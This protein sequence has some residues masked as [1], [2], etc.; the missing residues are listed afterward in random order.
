ML[1]FLY[2]DAGSR[3]CDQQSRRTWLQIGT[4]SVLGS[5]AA[6]STLSYRPRVAAANDTP[7]TGASPISD[8]TPGTKPR[9][10]ACIQIFLWGGPGAQ[11]TW[12]LK[13]AAPAENRGDFRPISTVVPGTQICEHLPRLAQRADQYTVVRSLTHE[14][15]NHG[16]SAYHMLTGHLHWSPGTLRHPTRN[17][18]PNIG[19]NAARHLSHPLHLPAHVHLP[20]IVNDGDGLP[21]PGQ[22]PGILGEAHQPFEVL[23]DLTA[24]DFKVSTLMRADGVSG[25]RLQKRSQL[26]HSLASQ[27]DYLAE[28]REGK[29]LSSYYERALA[30]L[31]SAQ[32]EAAF[33]LTQ[34]LETLRNAYGW[35]HFA[36]SLLLARRLVEA[37][38][39]FVTVYWNS[40]RN[41]DN[42]SWDTHNNQHVRMKDHLLPHFDQAMSAFLDDL[43]NRGLM[44]DVLVTWYGEF[45]RT[46]VINRAGG[47]DHWGFC[48]SIGLTGAGI[49]RGMVYGT[50]TRDGGYADQNP[51]RPDDLSATIFHLLG[52]DHTQHMYD[53]QNRPAPLSYGQVVT[54]LL[55]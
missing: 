14:G 51:V 20:S 34:E 9:A 10:K 49:R 5:A 33:D 44:D 41:T 26:V 47:R 40:P 22:G 17:D 19:V 53:L 28:L 8:S 32:T 46:P 2:P 39:P 21:V 25:E 38:V 1:N 6:G 54:D 23:G 4:A 13:P 24:R 48:Q 31:G 12:D 18:M 36:Q 7:G 16:T 11:E 45:G 3:L 42:Q 52:I 35:H 29:A 27:A 15:V 30:L 43:Q 50:S 55:V 37:G